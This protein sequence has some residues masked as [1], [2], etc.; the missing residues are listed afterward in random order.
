MYDVRAYQSLPMD[1]LL[2]HRVPDRMYVIFTVIV[3]AILT[4]SLV[5]SQM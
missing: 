2:L 4:F 5:G 1:A 3:L